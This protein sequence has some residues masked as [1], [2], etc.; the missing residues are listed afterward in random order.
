MATQYNQVVVNDIDIIET[1]KKLMEA[2]TGQGSAYLRSKETLIGMYK[3][4][5]RVLI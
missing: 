4:I 5:K 1:Y 2:S 3:S